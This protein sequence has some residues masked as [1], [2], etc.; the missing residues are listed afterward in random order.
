MSQQSAAM[1]SMDLCTVQGRCTLASLAQMT[2]CDPKQVLKHKE[3]TSS[4]LDTFGN[5]ELACGDMFDREPAWLSDD[6]ECMADDDDWDDEEYV[7]T[8]PLTT[9]G[10]MNI[11]DVGTPPS[12]A[13]TD[14]MSSDDCSSPEFADFAARAFKTSPLQVPVKRER[15]P[16]PILGG[17]VSIAADV[18]MPMQAIDV[19]PICA[20]MSLNHFHT[21]IPITTTQ[22]FGTRGKPTKKPKDASGL[23]SVDNS[24]AQSI[25]SSSSGFSSCT[26]ASFASTV[27]GGSCY[28]F[29]PG[30]VPVVQPPI[31][32]MWICRECSIMH[33]AEYKCCGKCC[34]KREE[35]EL[36]VLP[37]NAGEQLNSP[38]QQAA[39]AFAAGVGMYS[40]PLAQAYFQ[41]MQY[42][43][44]AFSPTCNGGGSRPSTADKSCYGASGPRIPNTS[45]RGENVKDNPQMQK[46]ARDGQKHWQDKVQQV[47][48]LPKVSIWHHFFQTK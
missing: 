11:A 30:F 8:P 21:A 14:T 5:L 47:C 22:I 34:K 42:R 38:Q 9:T 17:T 44:H 29:V 23:V 12:S 10:F 33:P 46:T 26:N 39:A 19:D 48:S 6:D 45:R 18:P 1:D 4:A 15:D 36:L 3:M 16:S 20:P 28:G 7:R 37:S 41:Q 40:N 24:D 43:S 13:F 35:V 2:S 25:A 27:S 32:V 31:I